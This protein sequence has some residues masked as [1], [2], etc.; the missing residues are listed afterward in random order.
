MNNNNDKNI[1]TQE[2]RINNLFMVYH[3]PLDAFREYKSVS[4]KNKQHKD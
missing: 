3:R 4:V 1:V 2:K